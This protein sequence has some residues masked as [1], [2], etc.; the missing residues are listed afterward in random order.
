MR[1]LWHLA[2]AIGQGLHDHIANEFAADPSGGSGKGHS[3]PIATVETECDPNVF[4]ASL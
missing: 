2:K 1:Q 3:L 4:A